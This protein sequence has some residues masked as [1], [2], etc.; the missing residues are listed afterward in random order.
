MRRSSRSLDLEFPVKLLH[1]LAALPRGALL[2]DLCF[3]FSRTRVIARSI[4]ACLERPLLLHLQLPLPLGL[5]DLQLLHGLALA[6]VTRRI[7]HA[8]Q[9]LL[10]PQLQL[11]LLLLTL[12][13]VLLKRARRR[14]IRGAG[15]SAQR[16]LHCSHG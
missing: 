3:R 10:H 9:V 1:L 12:K 13:L 14:I 5:V 15:G 7:L 11:V 8:A 16:Q 4:R 6:R 2:V